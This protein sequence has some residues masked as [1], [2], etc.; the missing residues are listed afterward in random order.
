M[1]LQ[2]LKIPN[3]SHRYASSVQ[4]SKLHSNKASSSHLH[5]KAAHHNS[6]RDDDDGDEI[7]S[8][9]ESKAFAKTIKF[10]RENLG[11]ILL[12]IGA[13]FVPSGIVM[14]IYGKDI[15][16]SARAQRK[17]IQAQAK[18]SIE[19]SRSGLMNWWGRQ[20]GNFNRTWRSAKLNLGKPSNSA[21]RRQR[22]SA[23]TA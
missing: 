7:R 20:T 9:R 23:V 22:A 17:A 19:Q 6:Q 3:T 12:T 11:Q 4:A 13:I 14:S 15:R 8:V 1:N 16:M 18:E 21:V 5:S 10:F 2:V